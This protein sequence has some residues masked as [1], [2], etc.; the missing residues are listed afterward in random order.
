VANLLGPEHVVTRPRALENPF[1]PITPAGGVVRTLSVP[2]RIADLDIN[3][4]VNNLHYVEWI[5]ESVPEEVW[6]ETTP[7]EIQV[8][9]KRA[10]RHGETVRI[11]TF[12][13]GDAYAHRVS[14]SGAP[15][16]VVLARTRWTVPG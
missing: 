4:H 10:V 1:A 14:T 5:V 2:V 6:R 16:D 13:T 7:A 15:G 8:E 9:F 11:D 12:E 3:D